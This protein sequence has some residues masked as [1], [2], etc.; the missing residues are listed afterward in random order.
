[1]ASNFEMAEPPD[2]WRGRQPK[3]DKLVMRDASHFF[4]VAKL[5]SGE[6]VLMQLGP[7]PPQMPLPQDPR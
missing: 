5:P 6:P 4:L 3:F 1:V 2:P 7:L